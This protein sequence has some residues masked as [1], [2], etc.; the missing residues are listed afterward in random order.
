MINAN[1]NKDYFKIISDYR[2]EDRMSGYYLSTDGNLNFKKYYNDFMKNIKNNVIITSPSTMLH[3]VKVRA[4]ESTVNKLLTNYSKI[5]LY[6]KTNTPSGF[7]ITSSEYKVEID[8]NECGYY[9]YNALTDTMNINSKN[10]KC[11]RRT[12]ETYKGT[13]II[14]DCDN[15]YDNYEYEHIDE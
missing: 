14:Y 13:K 3:D 9:D 7:K 6:E 2:E 15:L 8:S 5:Y 11:E 10:C 12:I 1:Y 4:N